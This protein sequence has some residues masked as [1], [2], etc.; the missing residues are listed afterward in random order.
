[1]FGRN[2]GALSIILHI[3]CIKHTYISPRPSPLSK[4]RFSI[5]ILLIYWYIYIYSIVTITWN[6]YVL[7]GFFKVSYVNKTLNCFPILCP[8]ILNNPFMIDIV[9]ETLE[10]LCNIEALHGTPNW[11]VD[12]RLYLAPLDCHETLMLRDIFLPWDNI[13]ECPYLKE[14]HL[15]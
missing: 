15:K 4:I 14:W 1:M 9:L 5:L 7:L 12:T 11:F 8:K 6:K 10:F 13:I 2:N 3:Y